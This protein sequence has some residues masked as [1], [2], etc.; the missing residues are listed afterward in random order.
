MQ[1]SAR[2][3]L[4]ALPGSS[5][6]LTDD[7]SSF[8]HQPASCPSRAETNEKPATGDGTGID[9]SCDD[10]FIQVFCPTGQAIFRKHER[11]GMSG[12][13]V[14]G[15]RNVSWLEQRLDPPRVPG[16]RVVASRRG[17]IRQTEEPR[18]HG[19]LGHDTS[20]TSASPIRQRSPM[21]AAVTS[22]RAVVRF[23]P[24]HP[25]PSG[26]ASAAAQVSRSSRA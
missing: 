14:R 22:S 3:G 25:L 1:A 26:R 10:A 15:R 13:S 19:I 16:V 17:S 4:L 2:R 9:C 18:R 20:R 12:T 21:S 23:S 24:K 6:I 11:T 7:Y 5:W 8:M